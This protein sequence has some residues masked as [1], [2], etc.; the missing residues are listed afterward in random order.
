MAITVHT[1]IHAYIQDHK[2]ELAIADYTAVLRIDPYNAHAYH[3]RGLA[4]DKIGSFDQA[5]ADFTKV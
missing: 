4:F 3:N 2:F 1:Y 5:I